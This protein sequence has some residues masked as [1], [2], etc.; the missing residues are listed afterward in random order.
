M[1]AKIITMGGVTLLDGNEFSKHFKYKDIELYLA[2][3]IDEETNK[4][5]LVTSLPS[6][7]ELNVQMIQYPIEFD[8]ESK[9]DE[10]FHKFDVKYCKI[11]IEELIETIKK[12][13]EKLDK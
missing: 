7:P 5:Y 2:K 6:I 10:A 3:A 9:R 12:Q 4:H 1:E 13:N 11:Y 8:L